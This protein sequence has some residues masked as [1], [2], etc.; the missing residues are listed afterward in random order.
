MNTIN[1]MSTKEVTNRHGDTVII[2]FSKTGNIFCP[3]CGI[4]FHNTSNSVVEQVFFGGT[5]GCPSCNTHFGF[6]ENSSEFVNLKLDLETK[7]GTL[8]LAWLNDQGWPDHAIEQL[9]NNLRI[10]MSPPKPID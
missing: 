9:W 10:N 5:E 4:E 3:V 8:R 6:S 2:H 1:F 7:W